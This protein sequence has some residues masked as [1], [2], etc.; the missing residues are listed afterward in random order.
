MP[1]REDFE[2]AY[3]YDDWA[4]DRLIHMLYTA[5]GEETD[6]TQTRDARTSA[7]QQTVAHLVGAQAVWRQRC[8]GHSPKALLDASEYPTP[9]ALRMAVGAE[10]ARFQGFLA[11]LASDAAFARPISYTTTQ[12]DPYTQSLC[13]ILQHVLA[14]SQY[15]RGQVTARLL[16]LGHASALL[17]TDLITFQREIQE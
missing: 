5:F 11:S 12:G 10:R 1:S 4:N 14:H 16:D 8:E 13:E 2:T 9:L 3:H 7:I 17:S 15:H 6:L